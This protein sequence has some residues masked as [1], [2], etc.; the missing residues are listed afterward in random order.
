MIPNRKIVLIVHNE[1]C[2]FLK[3]KPNQTATKSSIIMKLQFLV[4][5]PIVRWS[6]MI[7]R[8]GCFNLVNK[9]IYTIILLSIW[10]LT[11]KIWTMHRS[12]MFKIVNFHNLQYW[13]LF[14][15]PSVPVDVPTFS[16]LV[17]ISVCYSFPCSHCHSALTNNFKTHNPN[18]AFLW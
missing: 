1:C 3:K 17:C 10:P 6:F 8:S 7:L 9:V 4:V 15:L 2:L 18:L 16:K 12:K 5:G 11:S 14:W 13:K